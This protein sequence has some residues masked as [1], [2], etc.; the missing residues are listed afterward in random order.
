MATLEVAT[1]FTVQLDEPLAENGPTK[2]VFPEPGTYSDVPEEVAAHPY[3]APHLVGY[4][5]PPVE[6][7]LI[8]DSIVMV[9][10]HKLDEQAPPPPDGEARRMQAAQAAQIREARETHEQ[11]QARTEQERRPQQ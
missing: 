7:Q 9:P 4:E 10:D 6:D 5:P 1:P 11:E 3:A 2:F 8:G